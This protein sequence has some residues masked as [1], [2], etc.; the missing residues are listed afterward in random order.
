MQKKKNQKKKNRVLN[1]LK[2]RP[3]TTLTMYYNHLDESTTA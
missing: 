3:S 1:P 2:Q